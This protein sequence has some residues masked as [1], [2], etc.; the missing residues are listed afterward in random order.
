MYSKEE[1]IHDMCM[2][3]RHDYRLR[4]KPTDPPWTS[5]M[6]EEDAKNLYKVM[7]QIFNNNIEPMIRELY[8]LREGKSV[9]LP[10]NKEHAALMM[11][12][13]QMYFEGEQNESK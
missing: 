11:K 13:A 5:G 10:K 7:E 12:L 4:K 2:T 9:Q 1:I 8:D 6:T 3:Y